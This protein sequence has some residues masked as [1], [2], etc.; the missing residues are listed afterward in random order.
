MPTR[1]N[2]ERSSSSP[3]SLLTYASDDDRRLIAELLAEIQGTEDSSAPAA[4]DLVAKTMA[5]ASHALGVS[6][7]TLDKWLADPTFP[8]KRGTRGAATG[9][10]PIDEIRRWREAKY[11]RGD[12]ARVDESGQARQRKQQAEAALKEL[13]LERLAGSLVDREQA[14]AIFAATVAT[15]R[16]LLEELP[17]VLAAGLPANRPKLRRK[18][19]AMARRHVLRVLDALAA[20]L[21]D[22]ESE[23][24]QAE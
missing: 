1:K 22:E 18:V 17:E 12:G 23:E 20:D 8:G 21:K 11:G 24:E 9:S 2:P 3:E 19:S 4:N 13:Q 5:E 16:S 14:E 15:A 7:A 6:T 10:F